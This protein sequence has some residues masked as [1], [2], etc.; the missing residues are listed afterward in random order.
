MAANL[1]D[2]PQTPLGDWQAAAAKSAPGG[3]VDALT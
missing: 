1:N 3:N 2:Y